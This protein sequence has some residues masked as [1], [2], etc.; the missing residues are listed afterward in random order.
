M[1]L[2]C[3]VLRIGFS[4]RFPECSETRHA[5]YPPLQLRA[6]VTYE[7]IAT[8]AD[9]QWLEPGCVIK[10]R[11]PAALLDLYQRPDAK[12]CVAL[13]N[14]HDNFDAYAIALG[15]PTN[16]ELTI[17]SLAEESALAPDSIES[18]ALVASNEQL[19]FRRT[20]SGL[21]VRLPDGLAGSFAVAL[22]VRGPGLA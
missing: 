9:R 5:T 12:Y 15:W 21:T 20:R 4:P 10:R 13:A 2:A 3:R 6:E 1:W 18:V 11:E 19:N 22:K 14:H 8:P 16:G 7:L 17:T